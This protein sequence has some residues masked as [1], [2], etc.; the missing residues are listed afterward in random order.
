MAVIRTVNGRIDLEMFPGEPLSDTFTVQNQ[1]WEDSYTVSLET[2]AREPANETLALSAVLSGTDT[3]FT[4]SGT[5]A[6]K[7]IYLWKATSEAGQVRVQGYVTVA[8]L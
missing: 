6:N 8:T 5:V 3:V 7:G 1:D 2:W 4:F